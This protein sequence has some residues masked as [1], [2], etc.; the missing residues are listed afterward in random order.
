MK[1][2][3]KKLSFRLDENLYEFLKKFSQENNIHISNLIRNV[4][5]Y[6]HLA[7]ITGQLNKDIYQLR[8]DLNKGVKI[9]K[10]VKDIL[11]LK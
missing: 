1:S 5:I 3:T 8:N 10:D 2:K 7:Y 4:L 9:D 6:F 11:G